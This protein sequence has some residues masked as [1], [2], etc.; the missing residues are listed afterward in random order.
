MLNQRSKRETSGA[1]L[2]KDIIFTHEFLYHPKCTTETIYKHLGNM[3]FL[4]E[5]KGDNICAVCK[6]LNK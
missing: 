2:M 5:C 1:F 6:E 3:A 4:N